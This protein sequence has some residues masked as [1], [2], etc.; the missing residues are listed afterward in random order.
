MVKKILFPLIAIFLAYRSYELLKL[1]W[2]A[3]PSEFNLSTKFLLS[4]LLNL[5]I[6]GI[7]AFMGFAYKTN[8]LLPE[9]Y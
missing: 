4:L 5:F 9:N 6:T 3:E 7:F 2:F 1:L 8:R